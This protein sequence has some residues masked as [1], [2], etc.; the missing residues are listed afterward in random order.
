[1]G[2]P[3]ATSYCPSYLTSSWVGPTL[4]SLTEVS[5]L[6]FLPLCLIVHEYYFPCHLS[7][8]SLNF[9]IVLRHVLLLNLRS[10]QTCP[11]TINTRPYFSP[12]IILA[13]N[14][15]EDEAIMQCSL[16]M[17][18]NRYKTANRR[19][20][21]KELLQAFRPYQRI[22]RVRLLTLMM[23]NQNHIGRFSDTFLAAT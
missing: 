21:L 23:G 13:K 19:K 10:Q 2:S 5:F 20:T 22:G 16:D 15:P 1:M 18:L 6:L 11:Y 9:T 3:Y 17:N 7:I 8:F 4:P 12:T 14:R